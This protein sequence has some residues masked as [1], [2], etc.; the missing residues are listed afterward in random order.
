M[1]RLF[2]GFLIGSMLSAAGICYGQDRSSFELLTEK[3]SLRPLT[4]YKGHLQVNSGY[5]LSV[6]NKEFTSDGSQLDLSTTGTAAVKHLVP[7]SIGFG[8]LEYLQFTASIDYG[9]S[10]I[11]SMNRTVFG[12]EDFLE[13][14]EVNEYYGLTDMYLGLHLRSPRIL[15]LLELS[16]SGG[17]SVPVSGAKSKEPDH[18]YLGAGSVAILNYKYFHKLNSGVKS[19][20]FGGNLKVLSPKLSLEG[21]YSLRLGM[22]EGEGLVWSSE[23]SD[24]DFSYTSSSY[25]YS[26]GQ[27]YLI[28]G[29]IAWQTL[30]WL[31]IRIYASDISHI[32]R[33]S[34]EQEVK[35]AVPDEN[36]FSAGLGYE[37]QV[38]PSLRL[39]QQVQLPLSGKNAR[40]SFAFLT[41][42]SFSIIS[43][44]YRNAF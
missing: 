8:L 35:I 12:Y 26:T 24:D 14:N 9:K 10:G 33:W 23:L 27:S 25:N 6:L 40:A 17:L 37:I 36:I 34:E 19:A 43:E 44:S 28:Q 31:S 42:L 7:V 38:A 22:E 5:Q 21:N 30:D 20:V 15:N 18:S 39:V 2:T 11:R 1:K 32:N 13:I 4:L 16:A 41:G 29:S 3:Y